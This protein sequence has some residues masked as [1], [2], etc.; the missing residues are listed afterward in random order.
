VEIETALSL[1]RNSQPF[2]WINPDRPS[3]A[4]VLPALPLQFEDILDAED[5]LARFAPLL[6]GMFPELKSAQGLI[7]SD[8]R[9][10]D[11][12]AAWM[13][14]QAAG[15]LTGRILIK[16][17]H[18]LPVAGSV[19][20]RG[21]IYEVLLFAE[22]LAL[23]RGVLAAGDD[24]RMLGR[25]RVRELFRGYTISVGSTGNL[26]LSIG[27]TAAAL[28]FQAVVHMSREAK[29]WKKALLRSRGVT[30]IE[31]AADYSAAVAAGR[32]TARTDPTTYFVDDE[33]SRALFLGYSVAGLRLQEQLIRAGVAVDREHPLLVYLPCGV[34]GAPGGITFGLKHVFG[35]A[36]HCFFAEP[37]QAPC[38]L[39][40]LLSG[41]APP[42]SVASVGLSLDTA[43]DGLAV[44]QAS[45]LVGRLV[46]HLVSGVYTL[47]D[48][49]LFWFLQALYQTERIRIEPSAAAG[50]GGPFFICQATEGRQWQKAAHLPE[51]FPRATHLIWTTGG[52]LLPDA[53]F[54]SLRARPSPK[55]PAFLAAIT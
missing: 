11:A 52:H 48:D 38:M 54:E 47:D 15:P 3:A 53:E 1:L 45:G 39:L 19:K 34:G 20:A 4:E 41:F 14:R 55:V 22:T 12:M 35:D 29:A 44:G 24:L 9:P 2:L 46:R 40:G 5:R 8:L 32:E 37:V 21:G 26:G 49:S 30:V 25:N 31:H 27:V 23:E 36:V 51:K 7:E 28:G 50:F 33:D 17:D 42:R 18:D 13:N 10:V 16:T 6:A 43:A